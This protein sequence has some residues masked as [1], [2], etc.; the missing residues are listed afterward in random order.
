MDQ[1]IKLINKEI[2]LDQIGFS[3]EHENIY[4]V[5]F[6][7]YDIVESILIKNKDKGINN[8]SIYDI[9]N[10]KNKTDRKI[11]SVN[12]HVNR[13]G[14]NPFIGK[15]SKYNID[16]INIEKLYYQTA[17]GVTTYSCGN[18]I[19]STLPYPS[20]HLANLATLGKIFNFEIKGFLV[21][22]Y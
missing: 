3:L 17:Q 8:L 7:K 16:F 12:D 21:M 22:N 15:Q 18:K 20:T 4:I 5:D 19:N 13:I 10:I 9:T 1:E 6:K 2:S 11:L 14:T